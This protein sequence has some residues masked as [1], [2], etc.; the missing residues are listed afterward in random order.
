M[1]GF[2]SSRRRAGKGSSLTVADNTGPSGV[3]Q[4]RSFSLSEHNLKLVIRG[5]RTVPASS[6]STANLGTQSWEVSFPGSEDTTVTP[7]FGQ[8]RYVLLRSASF[9]LK[10]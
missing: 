1:A 4:Q 2:G 3:A 5:A 10:R 6:F 9:F 8:M 7:R